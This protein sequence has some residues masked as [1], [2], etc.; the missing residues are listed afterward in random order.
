MNIVFFTVS[1]KG[2]M[3]YIKDLA[4]L[5]MEIFR[6]YPYLYEGSLEYEE[7]YLNNYQDSDQAMIVIV[8]DG[9]GVVGASSALPLVNESDEIQQVFADAG[10]SPDEVFYFG[11]SLLMKQYRGRGFG[12]IFFDEREAFAKKLGTYNHTAFCAVQRP[13]NHPM[14]PANYKPLDAFWEKRGYIKRPDM[15]TWFSWNDIGHDSETQKPMM[16]WL[17]KLV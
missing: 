11:E 9:N 3:P 16:F 5:R 7:K 12:H 4:R 10:I 6:D 17:K 1:G 8:K 2:I 15:I 13:S 14:R